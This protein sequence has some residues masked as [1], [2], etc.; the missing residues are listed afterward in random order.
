MKAY[1]LRITGRVQGVMFRDSAREEALRLGVAGR[2]RNEPDGTVSAEAEGE[3][4][5]V[6]QFIEW[7]RKGPRMADVNRVETTPREPEGLNGFS[8]TG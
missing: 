4:H 8:V 3:D 7:C 5:A 1:S 2:I 6:D